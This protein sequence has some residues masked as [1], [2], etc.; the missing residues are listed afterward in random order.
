MCHS[1]IH[2]QEVSWNVGCLDIYADI[3]CVR[4]T[5]SEPD[6][7]EE[8]GYVRTDDG[9]YEYFFEIDEMAIYCD[10]DVCSTYDQESRVVIPAIKS[11]ISV[12]H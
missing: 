12:S 1:E 9:V 10:G 2:K 3:I 7:Y 6:S 5:I 11:L 8:D 4:N